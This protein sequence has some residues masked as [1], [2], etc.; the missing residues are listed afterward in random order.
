MI[1]LGNEKHVLNNYS[2]YLLFSGLHLSCTWPI[3]SEELVTENDDCNDFDPL[4]SQQWAIGV[5]L[6]E[7]LPVLLSDAVQEYINLSTKRETIEQLLGKIQNVDG[8]FDRIL[9]ILISEN[10]LRKESI[11]TIFRQSKSV[12]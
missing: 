10:I 3:F 2:I 5:T 4:L 8:N 6:L 1:L 12:Q 9:R 11:L 7:D